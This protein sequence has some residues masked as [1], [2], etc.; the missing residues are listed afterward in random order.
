MY[1]GEITE[2]TRIDING[3]DAIDATI[4]EVAATLDQ[5]LIEANKNNEETKD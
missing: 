5:R 3:M 2:V 4:Y 1:D